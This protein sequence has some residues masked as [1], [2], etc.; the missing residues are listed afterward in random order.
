MTLKYKVRTKQTIESIN[1]VLDLGI[2]KISIL[3]RHSDRFFTNEARQEPF[4]GLTDIGKDFAFDFGLKLRSNPIPKLCSSFIGR[5]IE[6]AYLIDKGFTKQNNI[7][8]D[9]NSL[10]NNLGPLYIKDVE[11][12]VKLVQEQE[13]NLFLRNWFDKRIDES[14]MEDPEKTSD[15]LCEFMVEQIKNL[16]KNQI[17]LCISHDW[18]I[19]PIKEFKMNLKHETDGDIGYLD[20]IVFFEKQNQYY[21]TNYQAEPILL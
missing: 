11:K 14:I 19:Y 18:S 16:K 1:K 15:N 21:I 10:T 9:H 3:I 8:L 7:S 5:C 4:M 13:N 17:A 2:T 20:A 6:T 12:A